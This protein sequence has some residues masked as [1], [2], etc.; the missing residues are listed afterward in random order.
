ML[1]RFNDATATSSFALSACARANAPLSCF[2]FAGYHNNTKLAVRRTSQNSSCTLYD[3][4]TLISLKPKSSDVRASLTIFK[5]RARQTAPWKEWLG[6]KHNVTT[7][8][9][10]KNE[11]FPMHRSIHHLQVHLPVNPKLLMWYCTSNNLQHAQHPLVLSAKHSIRKEE[12]KKLYQDNISLKL[13]TTWHQPSFNVSILPSNFR[14][15]QRSFTPSGP[16]GL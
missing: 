3:E 6:E 10:A 16:I 5:L 15:S 7:I 1:A 8:H 4:H 12:K 2:Q 11:T 13:N 14:T 9:R